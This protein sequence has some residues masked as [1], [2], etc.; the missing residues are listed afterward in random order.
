MHRNRF[1]LV[2]P[3]SVYAVHGSKIRAILLN[4]GIA[5]PEIYCD[6]A[7]LLLCVYLPST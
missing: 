7:L 6:S 4:K 5:C 3:K 1:L 2:H